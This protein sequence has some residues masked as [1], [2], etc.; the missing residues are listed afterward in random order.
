MIIHS[1]SAIRNSCFPCRIRIILLDNIKHICYSLDSSSWRDKARVSS[2][3][4]TPNCCFSI[5]SSGYAVLPFSCG[6]RPLWYAFPLS[7]SR[8][9]MYCRSSATSPLRLRMLRRSLAIPRLSTALMLIFRLTSVVLSSTILV[10]AVLVALARDPFVGTPRC[11]SC[12]ASL[13][14]LYQT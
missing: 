4:R 13:F 7:C 8:L 12:T 2:E 1:Q 10:D 5:F 9:L 6:F 11:G 14:F 3:P